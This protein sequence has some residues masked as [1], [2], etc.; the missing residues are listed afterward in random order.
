ML[1]VRIAEMERQIAKQFGI[2][3]QAHGQRS[4]TVPSTS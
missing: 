1:K 2:N 4:A 3:L